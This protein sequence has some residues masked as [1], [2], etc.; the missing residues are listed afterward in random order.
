MNV[1]V[2]TIMWTLYVGYMQDK[3]VGILWDHDLVEIDEAIVS[4]QR[5]SVEL[6]NANAL[7]LRI[8]VSFKLII[9]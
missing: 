1:D 5:N 4:S 7:P 8:N 9:L 2:S 6:L 3:K